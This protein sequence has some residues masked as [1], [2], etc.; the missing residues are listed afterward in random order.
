[1]LFQLP[2]GM[3]A[4]CHKSLQRFD[5]LSPHSNLLDYCLLFDKPA[6]TIATTEPRQKGPVRVVLRHHKYASNEK[7]AVVDTSATSLA[8]LSKMFKQKF[9]KHSSKRD[10]IIYES[11]GRDGTVVVLTDD[12]IAT[13][14]RERDAILCRPP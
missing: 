3:N 9:P 12:N 5:D 4:R 2:R 13:T 8:I 14:I 10:C 1:M 6:S 11:L 7:V